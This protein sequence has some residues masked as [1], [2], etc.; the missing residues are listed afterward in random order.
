[1]TL[2]GCEHAQ[3]GVAVDSRAAEEAE[4]A[5]TLLTWH[6][7]K[8]DDVRNWGCYCR[9]RQTKIDST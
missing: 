5:V 6:I 4:V 8:A 7:G 9:G 1:L 3:Q 2:T